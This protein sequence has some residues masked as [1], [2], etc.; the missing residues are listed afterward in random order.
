MARLFISYRRSDTGAYA[1][2]LAARLSLFQ[3]EAIFQDREGIALADNYADQ[4]RLALSRCDA[5][6]VLIGA[7]WAASSDGGRSRL[8]EPTDWVRREIALALSLGL[9]LIPVLFDAATV[10]AAAVMPGELAALAT[11][12]GYDINGNYFDRDADY[13]GRELEQLLVRRQ[14]SAAGQS[15]AVA[16]NLLGQLRL[17]WIVLG[18]LTLALAIA[19][20]FVP[21]L[22]RLF[23]LF[24]GTMAMAAFMWWLYWLGESL[25]PI[26]SRL[27]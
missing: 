20:F 11:A 1:D 26:R 16:T 15:A 22:P 17:I 13:L 25:R 19:P 3:F 2:R 24:P 8:A 18:A 12:Q 6:L 7:Q 14:R 23:W 27:A 9:P 21:S 4:I 10:P 5:V